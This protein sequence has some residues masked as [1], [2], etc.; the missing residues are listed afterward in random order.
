MKQYCNQA[1]PPAAALNQLEARS[2]CSGDGCTLTRLE[3]VGR[4][5]LSPI[6]LDREMSAEN[7]P[8]GEDYNNSSATVVFPSMVPSSTEESGRP[9]IPFAQ[10]KDL[11][12]NPAGQTHPLVD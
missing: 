1:E 4:I 9:P 5:R 3:D 10:S 7:S 12:L 8:Q 6:S 2:V 11:L